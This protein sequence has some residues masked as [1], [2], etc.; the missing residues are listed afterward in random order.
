MIEKDG[1]KAFVVLPYKEF[2][3]IQNILEDY[4]D[5]RDLRFA[6]AQS[7]HEPTKSLAV[8]RRN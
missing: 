1:K 7:K 6:K 4:E 2:S 3:E 5:L 8:W